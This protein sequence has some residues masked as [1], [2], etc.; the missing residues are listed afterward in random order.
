MDAEALQQL[1]A[2]LQGANGGQ[3]P[4]GGFVNVGAAMM[5]PHMV[6]DDMDGAEG[7][8]E[9]TPDERETFINIRDCIQAR[10]DDD[11][12]ITAILS[13]VSA[14]GRKKIIHA[15][16]EQLLRDAAAR[17]CVRI[18]EVLLRQGGDVDWEAG[19]DDDGFADDPNGDHAMVD[20]I[21]NRA[22]RHGHKDII[23]LLKSHADMRTLT[24]AAP[25]A[26]ANEAGHRG[27]DGIIPLLMDAPPADRPRPLEM[28]YAA[29]SVLAAAAAG[30]CIG[31]L[32]ELMAWAA[33]TVATNAR[34]LAPKQATA[35]AAAMAVR[36][37]HENVLYEL[38]L[39]E[40]P[41]NPN[42]NIATEH[43]GTILRALGPLIDS[44][45]VQM[46]AKACRILV[47]LAR[48]RVPAED[49]FHW[50]DTRR[51]QQAGHIEFVETGPGAK[52][53]EIGRHETQ[54]LQAAAAGDVPA[55]LREAKIPHTAGDELSVQ[56]RTLELGEAFIA[57]AGGGHSAL[58]QALLAA[59]V[60][61]ACS[62]VHQAVLDVAVVEA[63]ASGASA[64]VQWLLGHTQASRG[65]HGQLAFRIACRRGHAQCVEYLLDGG[66]PPIDVHEGGEEAFIGACRGGHTEVAQLLVAHADDQG[67]PIDASSKACSAL[68]WAVSNGHSKC[69]EWLLALPAQHKIF[70]GVDDGL[71]IQPAAKNGQD[72]VLQL[73]LA[74]PTRWGSD[75]MFAAAKQAAE[76]GQGGCLQ[77]LLSS[78]AGQALDL[79]ANH[80][81]L[82]VAACKGGDVTAVQ[83][84]AS[85]GSRGVTPWADGPPRPSF[86]GLQILPRGGGMRG[87]TLGAV[88]TPM[89][90]FR[91]A[92][93]AMHW[94]VVQLM[95]GWQGGL[96]CPDRESAFGILSEAMVPDSV[97]V[98]STK[99][100]QKWFLFLLR[101]LSMHGDCVAPVASVI[102]VIQRC[103][104]WVN[105]NANLSEAA[106]FGLT[107]GIAAL[108]PGNGAAVLASMTPA[109]FDSSAFAAAAR[110]RVAAAGG[111][112]AAVA[113]LVDMEAAG[114]HTIAFPAFSQHANLPLLNMARLMSVLTAPQPV[115]GLHF[116]FLRALLEWGYMQTASD[117]ANMKHGQDEM[118][119]D[120]QTGN[121]VSFAAAWDKLLPKA[122]THCWQWVREPVLKRAAAQHGAN[123][124]QKRR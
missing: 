116:L 56:L 63:A 111:V 99:G 28:E 1:M 21:F 27:H 94:G 109:G 65:A 50:R 64:T 51:L 93:F 123:A 31:D 19:A 6:D 95:L 44:Q 42:L 74:S 121:A 117:I 58:C 110:Q 61:Q 10:N 119:R 45:D 26:G 70:P 83:Y 13:A 11:D 103:L 92:C 87:A 81:E 86:G 72:A 30:G 98:Y 35:E 122:K 67:S 18:L 105:V 84:L 9:L 41:F 16:W 2:Q 85:L 66:A 39:A 37:A 82:F 88:G 78:A 97:A 20:T 80:Q 89:P 4:G 5:F 12:M 73:L 48:A 113:P 7:E 49:M 8:D 106:S 91:A 114:A 25:N 60:V 62:A 46:R 3:Q 24:N 55:C 76:G 38:L 101:V 112:A 115:A 120:Y 77:L 96:A 108:M 33:P 53:L 57:A 22:C 107:A 68:V 118:L 54:L 90:A 71:V 59:S 17:G 124:H 75:S 100:A 36:G 34:Q 40:A 52:A 43:A 79:T 32:R 104:H 14:E 29:G 15:D 69:A 102:P 23:K 47:L